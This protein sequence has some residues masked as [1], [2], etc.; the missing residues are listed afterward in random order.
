MTPCGRAY[1]RSWHPMRYI[2]GMDTARAHVIVAVFCC[3]LQSPT[4]RAA[5]EAF[6]V[7]ADRAGELPRGKEADGIVGDFVLRNDRVEAVVSGN[8]PRRRA[9]MSTFYG[10]DGTTPGCLYDLTLRGANNDQL[11]IF[12]P[13]GQQGSVSHV[14]IVKDGA[15]DGEAV[16]ETVVTAASKKGIYKRHEYRLR[17][18][19]QGVLVVTTL[20]NETAAPLRVTPPDKWTNFARYSTWGD[21]RWADAVDPADKA[22]YAFAWVE[23]DGM[24][25]PPDEVNLQPGQELTFAR[26]VAVGRSPLEAVGVVAAFR[27]EGGTVTGSVKQED[28]SPVATAGLWL[29]PADGKPLAAYPDDKGEFSFAARP[30]SYEFELADV[31]RDAQP[32]KVEVKPGETARLDLTVKP[33]AAIEFDVKDA[34]GKS[35][36]CK[37][38]FIG[39]NGTPSPDLGPPNRAH[40]C[41]DQYHSATGAFRVQVP[42]GAY[43]VVVTHG[44]E[45][46]HLAQEVVVRPG[47]THRVAG[48]LARLVDT[49]GWISA[50]FHNHSTP[51]GDNTCGTPDRII[52]LAAEQVEF[53]PTTEHNRLY[54]WRPTIEALGLA[55]ELNTVPGMELTGGGEHLNGFPFKPDPTLQDGGAPEWVNDPRINALVLREFQGVEP[56]R[57]VQLN[58]PTVVAD[59][60]D[61]NGDGKPDGGYLHLGRL[62]DGLETQNFGGDGILS[63]VPWGVYKQGDREQV[64]PHAEGVWLRMLNRGDHVW[65]VAVSD[66]HSVHGNGVGGWRTYVR[67]PTDDPAKVDWRDVTRRARAGQM[68]LSNGPFLE[69]A[70]APDGAIAGGVARAAGGSIDLRVRV[71]CADWLD[72]DRVQ[73]LVNGAARPD[74]NFTRAGHADWFAKDVVRFD[75]TIPVPLAEDAHLIVVAYGG[76]STLAVGFGS[77]DQASMHPCAYNNPIFVD[78]DGGGFKANGDMLGFPPAAKPSVGDVKKMLAR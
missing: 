60:F 11:T 21:V 76:S 57:W 63:P 9:N 39:V 70:T 17:D 74:L 41:R 33:A 38:Q 37:A 22:G 49:T 71:Q 78:V 40:G 15:A 2:Q 51:S 19:W 1:A 44:P 35:I 64:Y 53:A 10:P 54:D 12:S 42:P 62:I 23:R 13:S 26:F 65:G 24:T 31:G 58:H 47:E 59:F 52:N 56:D 29:K 45:F 66:A 46:G 68:V 8:L 6:E 72:V 67:S 43:R 30:G 27:G 28:G 3:L 50:D 75:R 14:R 32:V 73:V 18:G 61:R 5:P 36:P 4:A 69:V 20:R 25:A 77:S 7:G 55:A 16:V 48:T 34:A